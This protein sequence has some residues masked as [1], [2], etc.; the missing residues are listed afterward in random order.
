VYID[1][2]NLI[3]S[4]DIVYVSLSFSTLTMIKTSDNGLSHNGDIKDLEG[5]EQRD[6]LPF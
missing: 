3:V 1:V 2:N 5:F 6:D 4:S